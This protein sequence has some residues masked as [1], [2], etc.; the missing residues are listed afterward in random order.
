MAATAVA[1]ALAAHAPVPA[2]LSFLCGNDYSK[3]LLPDERRQLALVQH[4]L[5][6]DLTVRTCWSQPAAWPAR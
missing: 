5:P 6:P 4:R 2:E 3:S 1:D